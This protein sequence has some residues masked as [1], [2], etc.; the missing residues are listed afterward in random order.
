M[1][2]K[3]IK[4]NNY[5]GISNEVNI[6]L[7]SYNC[8]VGKNDVGKSTIL[9]A[10]DSFLLD[11]T[12]TYEDMNVF[13]T[14]NS[15]VI[16]ISFLI[17]LEI[18]SI[19]ESITTTLEGEELVDENGL[20]TIRKIWDCSKKTIKPD[21]YVKRKIYETDF[22]ML[23][24]RELISLC[25]N[26]NISTTKANGDTF[27]N[28]EKR[29]KIRLYYHDNDISFIHDYTL[30]PTTGK[31]RDKKILDELKRILP[32]FEY[33]KADNSLSESDLSIQKY[34]REKAL[35]I[36]ERQIDTANVEEVIRRNIK[37]TL[38]IITN[39]INSIVPN[40]EQ[41]SSKIIFDWSKLVS[42]TFD[43][44]KA[45][46]Q[47]PLSSRGD[48]FRRITMMSYFEMLAEEK[49]E[50]KNIIF[51]FE[52]PETFL[53]PEMQKKLSEKLIEM[54]SAGYQVLVTTHSPVIVAQTNSDNIIFINKDQG[55]YSIS[56]KE[57]ISISQIINDL[58][59]KA[60]D[61][62]VNL[63]N[64]I[65]AFFLLEGKDDVIAFNH[66]ASVYKRRG[67]IEH[68]FK[69]LNIHLLPIGGCGSIQTWTN[70]SIIKNLKR[71][72]YILLDSDKESH[73]AV[74]PNKEKL[75]GL[76][77]VENVDF[78][79]TRKREIE[80]YIPPIYFS[81][82]ANPISIS[83]NDWDDVK[84]ISKKHSETIR[85]G[86]K[87]ICEKHFKILRYD[88]LQLTFNPSGSNDEFLQIYNR[89]ISKI[90]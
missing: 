21:W 52:E 34:F 27:N 2:I 47:I 32:S 69:E 28:V 42:T 67:I 1:K 17:D 62:I 61:E 64:D 10:V 5:R 58:G 36:L 66:I 53:H 85:L 71:P 86:G 84:E 25:Q 22:V 8:L 83:Y 56:Q 73:D 79:V 37:S 89:L 24:E 49:H 30:L 14:T 41:V 76:G 45:E 57:N 55:E 3:S 38:D 15:I 35:Q 77:Y 19:D 31:G 80:N 70:L 78:Q 51:G 16:E 11:K 87:K 60:D 13:S 9:K 23:T 48:G 20:L 72:F 40:E 81:E 63:F 7:D 54:S 65:K 90:V 39:K 68:D 12:L 59:I 75:I 74:S 43:C 44:K 26:S 33:F 29:Q 88:Q 18:I 4:I 6:D 50:D 82:Y 46:A